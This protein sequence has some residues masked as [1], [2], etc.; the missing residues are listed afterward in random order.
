M[1]CINN[2][3]DLNKITTDIKSLI[4]YTVDDK[5]NLNF[6]SYTN[7]TFLKINNFPRYKKNININIKSPH[8][9]NIICNS[10]SINKIIQLPDNLQTLK[11][12]DNFVSELPILPNSLIQLEFS[13]NYI[14]DLTNLHMLTNLKILKCSF[15]ARTYT[16]D[17]YRYYETY[18]IELIGFTNIHLPPNIINLEM[19]NCCLKDIKFVEINSNQISD[20]NLKSNTQLK[21]LEFQGNKISNIDYYPKSIEIIKCSYNNLLELNNL[22]PKL[23]ILY[24]TFNYI[25]QLD[26]LPCGLNI[27]VCGGN[28]ITRLDNLPSGLIKLDVGHN[29]LLNLDNLPSSLQILIILSNPL[30]KLNNLPVHLTKLK[31]FKC[32]NIKKLENI[33]KN[34]KI[35]NTNI[36]LE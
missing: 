15:N 36:L 31:I 3:N 25:T 30:D 27:L 21:I 22:P 12:N 16:I 32:K 6:E 23:K 35:I 29:Q 28:K 26:N 1:I 34:I 8:I 2:Q 10:N 11:F 24:C 17:N 18:D 5:L 13:K 7:L 20:L 14:V 33:P 9:K 19:S 4:M